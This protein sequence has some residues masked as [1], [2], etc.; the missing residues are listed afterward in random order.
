MAKGPVLFVKRVWATWLV[1]RRTI[2]RS[3]NLGATYDWRDLDQLQG[4]RGQLCAEASIGKTMMM[5][6][7]ELC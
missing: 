3:L 6:I 7:Q 2:R 1:S 5:G 4:R